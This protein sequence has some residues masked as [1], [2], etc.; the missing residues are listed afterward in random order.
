ME[1][2]VPRFSSQEF[3]T[4]QPLE[5]AAEANY[6]MSRSCCSIEELQ[7]TSNGKAGE[8]SVGVQETIPAQ[9]SLIKKS[10]LTLRVVSFPTYRGWTEQQKRGGEECLTSWLGAGQR[11]S[12]GNNKGTV[13]LNARAGIFQE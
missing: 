9:G 11:M 4:A 3:R 8:L 12:S 1:Y 6:Q 13:S 2:S 7:D 5:A 10:R